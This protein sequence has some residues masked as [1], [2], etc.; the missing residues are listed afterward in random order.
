[1]NKILIIIPTY[2]EAREFL[3][4]TGACKVNKNLFYIPD[5][6]AHILI[7]GPGMPA[8]M[9]HTIKYLNQHPPYHLLIM[10]GLA[11]SYNTNIKLCDLVCV[12]TEK[13]AD[14]GYIHN[15]KFHCL[16]TEDEWESYYQKGVLVNSFQT[17]RHETGLKNVHSNTVNITNFAIQGKPDADIEN[18]EGAGFFM[19]ANEVNIPF[20]EIRAISN[21]V[22]ERDKSKWK[23]TTA[24]DN[25]HNYLI[26]Y[27]KNK[28]L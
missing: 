3:N 19:L 2:Y 28:M 11:G 14:I 5:L 23:N 17:L 22:K 4:K 18:M 10:A 1:M 13:T 25:L 9:L 27:L 6:S 12:E 20:L 26:S 16:T 8:S 21:Y 15:Q 24:L 7:C